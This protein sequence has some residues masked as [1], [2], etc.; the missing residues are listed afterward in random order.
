[1][2]VQPNANNNQTG[3]EEDKS[4]KILQINLNKSEKAHLEV[5]NEQVSQLYDI[6][7]IQEPYTMWQCRAAVQSG[8]LLT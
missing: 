6:I 1:M 4:I 5:I 2:S 3:T 7:L 8:S